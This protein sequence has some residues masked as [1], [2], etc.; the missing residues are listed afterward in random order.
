MSVA[1]PLCK[2]GFVLE[3]DLT[4]VENIEFSL[5]SCKIFVYQF[6]MATHVTSCLWAVCIKKY[7]TIHM[8]THTKKCF[9]K[10]INKY[11]TWYV[12]WKF[13]LCAFLFLTCQFSQM[14]ALQVSKWIWLEIQKFPGQVAESCPRWLVALSINVKRVQCKNPRIWNINYSLIGYFI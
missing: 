7:K 13:S 3:A 14:L 4:Y 12:S 8:P 1:F 9:F 10:K 11:L 2:N 6:Y 5:I